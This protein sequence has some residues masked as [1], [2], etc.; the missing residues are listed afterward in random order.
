MNGPRQ[1]IGEPIRGAAPGTS[2]LARP[3]GSPPPK[4]R[5]R[6]LVPLLVAVTVLAV[7]AGGVALYRHVQN[8]IAS[9]RDRDAL[10]VGDRTLVGFDEVAM[11]LPTGWSIDSYRSGQPQWN[12]V[13]IPPLGPYEACVS[14]RAGNVSDIQLDE[15][16][17]PLG[18]VWSDVATSEATLADGTMALIGTVADQTLLGTAGVP[19]PGYTT[20]VLVIPQLDAILVGSSRD[21]GRLEALLLATTR[22]PDGAAAVPDLVGVPRAEAMADLDHA[23]LVAEATRVPSRAKGVVV[24]VAPRAG[25]VVPA[26]TAIR[27]GVGR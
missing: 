27:V 3:P 21:P 20:T 19:A 12:T 14:G 11:P 6:N 22:M 8:E 9:W 2:P 5:G 13:A 26:G 4:P 25:L 15:L 16:G 18:R 1:R 10:P 17:S 7:F 23:G 24:D